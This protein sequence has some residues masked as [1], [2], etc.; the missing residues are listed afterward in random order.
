M[1]IT[2]ALWGGLDFNQVVPFIP[3]NGARVVINVSTNGTI[4]PESYV[5]I[6]GMNNNRTKFFTDTYFYLN[7]YDIKTTSDVTIASYP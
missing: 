3:S 1:K 7:Y 5:I 6:G 2:G 4:T